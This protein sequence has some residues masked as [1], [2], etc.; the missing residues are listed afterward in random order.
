MTFYWRGNQ[1]LTKQARIN[2]D[3]KVWTT[4]LLD[5][6]EKTEEVYI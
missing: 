1:L 6:R 4:F 5:M 3:D 2:N